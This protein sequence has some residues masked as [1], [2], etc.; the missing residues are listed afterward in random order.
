MLKVM[1]TEIKILT[2]KHEY[3]IFGIKFFCRFFFFFACF[4]LLFAIRR[5][6]FIFLTLWFVLCCFN[7]VRHVFVVIVIV[8]VVVVCL[9]AVVATFRCRSLQHL[10][11]TFVYL[12]LSQL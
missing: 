8:V 6:T 1:Y 4:L 11:C 7:I 12:Q 2:D 9:F 5:L 10:F 3:D